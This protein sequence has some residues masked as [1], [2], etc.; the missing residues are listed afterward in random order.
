MD[1]TIIP[2][3]TALFSHEYIIFSAGHLMQI[4]VLNLHHV[5]AFSF[6]VK[7]K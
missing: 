5:T 1:H 4:L 7:Q 2:Q 3:L 6:L